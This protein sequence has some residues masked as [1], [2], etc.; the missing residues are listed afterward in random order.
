[1]N[2]DTD[3]PLTQK[4]S[5][6]KYILSGVLFL[7]GNLLVAQ[8]ST[9]YVKLSTT[10]LVDY[11]D[12]LQQLSDYF[13]G[14][15]VVGMGES[16]HG[17]H[18]FFTMRHRVFKYL[19]EHHGYNTFFL[20]ADY[21][22]CLR[23]NEFI[24]G[25]DDNVK[26]VVRE[27]RIWPWMTYE[28]IDLINWMR[29]YNLAHTDDQLE[30]IGVDAQRFIENIEKM[31]DLLAANN[32]VTTDSVVYQMLLGKNF[33]LIDKAK[34]L[35]QYKLAWEA[36]KAINISSM[37][38]TDHKTYTTLLR[39]LTQSL[40]EKYKWD[41][42]HDYRD[43]RMAENIMFFLKNNAAA[44]GFFWAHSGHVFKITYKEGKKKEWSTAGG[45][46]SKQLDGKYFN[47]G[48]DFDEGSFNAYYPDPSSTKIIHG[49]AYTL[50]PIQVGP[51][52]EGSFVSRYRYLESPVFID[53][54]HLPK[55]ERVGLSS[56]GA[57]YYLKKDGSENPFTR[58][59][60]HGRKSFDAIILIST[61][62]PT[63]LLEEK[64]SD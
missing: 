16:T 10:D 62:T 47:I 30:F 29:A 56:I 57:V 61:S 60:Y 17:T 21:A 50:G 6:F 13:N 55:K 15:K 43:Q 33:F 49:E 35:E 58:N 24:H 26:D 1:M 38:E 18:E 25:K 53:C 45:H 27:I 36:K 28:M 46:L 59:N 9:K 4:W 44:K 32:L 37:D 63:L 34:D 64:Q 3:M 12:D 31:D 39:H 54:S 5:K 19:V 42:Y 14:V 51:S 7:V 23:A 40:S 48:Q 22:N 20:E 8:D 11:D 41:K 2:Y 52:P